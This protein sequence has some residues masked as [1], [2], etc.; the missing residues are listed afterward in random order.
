[1]RCPVQELVSVCVTF[2]ANVLKSSENVTEGSGS[3]SSC[4]TS[5]EKEPVGITV[6]E[7]KS[8]FR[9]KFSKTTTS[10]D[11]FSICICIAKHFPDKTG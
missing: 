9:K 11:Y 8:D 2:T 6:K 5:A 7:Y 1:M 10:C 4:K 3:H